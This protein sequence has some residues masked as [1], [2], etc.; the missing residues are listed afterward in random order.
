[1]RFFPVVCLLAV[2]L[3]LDVL[4]EENRADN[5]KVCVFCLFIFSLTASQQRKADFLF[6]S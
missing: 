3:V 6:F 4:M 5:S 2:F 1:M